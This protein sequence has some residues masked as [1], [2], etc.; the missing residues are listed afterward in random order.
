MFIIRKN[1]VSC[2]NNDLII[3]VHS[4]F[5]NSVGSTVF[6]YIFIQCLNATIVSPTRD[7]CM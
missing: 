6:I 3:I 7:L 2:L 4:F 5:I 1:R